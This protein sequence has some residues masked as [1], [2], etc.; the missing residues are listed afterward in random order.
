LNSTEADRAQ[1]RQ[2]GE[3]A[4]APT[5]NMS[6]IRFLS[7]LLGILLLCLF[8]TQES[9]AEDSWKDW[10]PFKSFESGRE[11]EKK[12]PEKSAPGK[13]APVP[14]PPA[15]PETTSTKTHE[16]TEESGLVTDKSVTVIIGLFILVIGI[17]VV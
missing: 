4:A 17:L 12:P 7:I 8:Q 2:Y 1:L 10:E 15:K 6:Q 14:P 3:N 9:L 13:S 16:E 5:T 11:E